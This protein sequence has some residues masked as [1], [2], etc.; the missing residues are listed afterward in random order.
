M[1]IAINSNYAE[2]NA[3]KIVANRGLIIVVNLK[4]D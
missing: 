4:T 2:I 1:C 3:N